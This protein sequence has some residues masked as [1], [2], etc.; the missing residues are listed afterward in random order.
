M[1]KC[2]EIMT[3]DPVCCSTSDNVQ[4]AAQLMK[5]EDVGPIPVVE[6][7]RTKKLI[8]IVT[9]RDLV[10]KVLAEGRD[11]VNTLVND[12]MSSEL[13]TCHPEDDLQE[14]MQLMSETQVRRIPVIDEIGILVGIIAQADIATRIE[15]PEAVE[16]VLEKISEP[17]SNQ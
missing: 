14:A 17:A 12:V 10:L 11:P 6:D 1:P 4:R 13:V 7:E 9:D 8:G 16:D 2:S 5:S 15:Q 3:S